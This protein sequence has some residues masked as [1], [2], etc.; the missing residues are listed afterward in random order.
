[1]SANQSILKEVQSTGMKF[2][3]ATASSGA[4]AELEG[5]NGVMGSMVVKIRGIPHKLVK[6]GA[7]K[8]TLPTYN[9]GYINYGVR[10]PTPMI[11]MEKK[12]TEAT[13]FA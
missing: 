6:N 2:K 3:H 13:G 4:S 7:V 5:N 9:K 12:P 10:S 8:V 11:D 1:M